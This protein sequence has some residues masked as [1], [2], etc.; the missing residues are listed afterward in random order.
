MSNEPRTRAADTRPLLRITALFFVLFALW[1]LV[2]APTMDGE[3]GATGIP[4]Y[5]LGEVAFMLILVVVLWRTGLLRC[6]GFRAPARLRS[7]W[8]GTPFLLLA[9]LMLAASRDLDTSLAMVVGVG[10]MVL[11]GSLTEEIIFR[12]TL[13]EGLAAMEDTRLAVLQRL[14]LGDPLFE[15]EVRHSPLA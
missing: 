14:D 2:V 6:A 9:G 12:G 7:M 5:P 4:I 1:K 15:W 10:V 3:L 13:W 8:W 11:G